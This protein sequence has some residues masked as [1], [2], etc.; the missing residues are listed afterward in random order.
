MPVSGLRVN[1]RGPGPPGSLPRRRGPRP[2]RLATG[3]HD[4]EFHRH[5]DCDCR[6]C[7]NQTRT[8]PGALSLRLRLPGPGESARF[9]SAAAARAAGPPAYS[10]RVSHDAGIS[11]GDCDFAASG[12]WHGKHAPRTPGIGVQLWHCQWLAAPGLGRRA[13]GWASGFSMSKI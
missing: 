2:G 6:Q 3:G 1:R 9:G 5:C 13:R 7:D 10:G 8:Q 4:R 12:S 11:A